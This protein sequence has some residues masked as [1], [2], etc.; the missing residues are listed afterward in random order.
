MVKANECGEIYIAGDCVGLGYI[1]NKDLTEQ[2]FLPDILADGCLMYKTGDLGRWGKNGNVVYI[3]RKDKQVKIR[4]YR[5]ELG[6]IEQ[7]L[8]RLAYIEGAKVLVRQNEDKNMIVAYIQVRQPN[9]SAST[10]NISCTLSKINCSS[11][12]LTTSLSILRKK[13]NL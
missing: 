11:S 5:V 12:F 7:A 3:G 9:I 2:A 6:E 13:F 1:N 10:F 8:E 4:G